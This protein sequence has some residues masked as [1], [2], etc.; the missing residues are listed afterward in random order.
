MATRRTDIPD[1]LNPLFDWRERGRGIKR[2]LFICRITNYDNSVA[3]QAVAA[4]GPLI[5][6]RLVGGHLVGGRLVGR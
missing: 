1:I 5:G 6:G 4:V 3:L 2:Y